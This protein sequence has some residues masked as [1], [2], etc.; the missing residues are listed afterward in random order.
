LSS[1]E[2][3]TILFPPAP[4]L[5]P[6]LPSSLNDTDKLAKLTIETSLPQQHND[7]KRDSTLLHQ[8]TTVKL[9]S[10]K[11]IKQ[12]QKKGTMTLTDELNIKINKMRQHIKD[13]DSES[14]GD[15]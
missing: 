6:P 5:P 14:D 9:R 13:S 15:Y 7:N 8:I 11:D 12:I 2:S 4:P 10:T 1:P 3:P